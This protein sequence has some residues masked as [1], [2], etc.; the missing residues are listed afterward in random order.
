MKYENCLILDNFTLETNFPCL[1][2]VGRA[3]RLL[4]CLRITFFHVKHSIIIIV[5]IINKGELQLIYAHSVVASKC[6]PSF[7]SQVN[8][9]ASAAD[10]LVILYKTMIQF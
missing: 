6:D 7:Q 2:N 1:Q 3:H 8:D 10:A 9:S 5:I 4:F